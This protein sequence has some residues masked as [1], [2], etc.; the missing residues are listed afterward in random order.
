MTSLGIKHAGTEFAIFEAKKRFPESGNAYCVL[1]RSRKNAIF[2][3]NDEKCVGEPEFDIH[4]IPRIQEKLYID[5]KIR[6][7]NIFWS[8]NNAFTFHF[9]PKRSRF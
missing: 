5:A 9:Y 4:K 7:N 6:K 2:V 8:K 3:K 1:K